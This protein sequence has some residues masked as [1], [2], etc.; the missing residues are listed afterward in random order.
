VVDGRHGGDRG[1]P[2]ERRVHRSQRRRRQRTLDERGQGLRRRL[3][4]R[5]VRH[6]TADGDRQRHRRQVLHHVLVDAAVGEPGQRRGAHRRPHDGLGRGRTP[7]DERDG[8]L[9]GGD[10]LGLR[11]GVEGA[12]R[13]ATPRSRSFAHGDLLVRRGAA[14]AVRRQDTATAPRRANLCG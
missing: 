13:A 10:R 5:G 8:A 1:E 7:G 6:P 4:G 2:G 3:R 9:G 11:T 14:P 12:V